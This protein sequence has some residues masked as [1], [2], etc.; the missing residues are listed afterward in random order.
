MAEMSGPPIARLLSDFL[1]R[2]DLDNTLHTMGCR[3][4]R[5]SK[6]FGIA[7]ASEKQQ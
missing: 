1:R 7:G 5:P 3:R 6:A 2:P 4:S